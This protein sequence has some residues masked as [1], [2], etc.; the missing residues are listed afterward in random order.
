MAYD[1][2]IRTLQTRPTATMRGTTTPVEVG[3][4]P[5]DVLPGGWVAV[6]WHVG[7]YEGLPHAHHAII[8][9]L[10][11]TGHEAAG[12]PWEVYWTDPSEVPD[13][14]AWRTEVFHPI[15]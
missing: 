8:D 4:T 10:A 7:P 5:G 9:W 12:A 15:R 11:D 3:A 1:I 13:P 14:A 2:E 6:T